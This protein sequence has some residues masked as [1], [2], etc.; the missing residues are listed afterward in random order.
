M[1]SHLATR[2]RHAVGCDVDI[3]RLEMVEATAPLLLAC[4]LDDGRVIVDRDG[5][6]PGVLAR[7]DA[8]EARAERSYQEQMT[9]AAQAGL[10]LS[11]Q[12]RR[13]QSITGHRGDRRPSHSESMEEIDFLPIVKAYPAV[14]KRHGEVAC[15][16]GVQFTHTD[17]LS[18]PDVHW[19]RLFPV[20]FRDL[21]DEQQFA[22]YQPIR[23]R[24]ESHSSDSRPETRRPDRESIEVT[25]DTIP[26][27]GDWLGRRPY[28]EPLMVDSMCAIQCRQKEDRTSLGLFRPAEILG[29]DI[30]DIDVKEEKEELAQT[31]ARREAQG[32][33]LKGGEIDEK[34]ELLGALDLIPH[35][36]KLR[37]R[38][39][40]S[41]C[42]GHVQ[43]IIDW[44]ILQF[45]RREREKPDWEQIVRRRVLEEIC[46]PDRDVALVVGN[47]H[48]HENAFLVLGFWWPKRIA[49]QLGLGELGDIEH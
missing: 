6:W 23:V 41:G 21:E 16:A 27:K 33:L 31:M 40:D 12:D 14:S 48:Q 22:K 28:V 45:Y 34:A 30:E 39:A 29:L 32:S 42:Q 43:S 19:V 18:H 20:P 24:V 8:V 35:R 7:R 17:A 44:E 2:I 13:T 10:E 1:G 5:L 49:E 36:F 4:A 37:Y 11:C 26:A 38:C 25:G 3:A 15:I 9:E 47:Q 46:A